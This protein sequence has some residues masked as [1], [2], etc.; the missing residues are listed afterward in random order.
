MPDHIATAEANANFAL[1]KY[2]GKRD[3]QRNLPSVG[4]ISL[5]VTG[6]FSR[7]TVHFRT[8]LDADVLQMDDLAVRGPRLERVARF[9]DIIRERSGLLRS[10]MIH[11]TNS[12]P[13]GAGLASS[14]SGFAALALASCHASGLSL[15]E[16]ELGALARRGSGSAARSMFGG[17]VEMHRGSMPDGSDA[18]AEQLAGPDHW[19]LV[20]LVVVTDTG[21]KSMGSTRA[22]SLS[23]ETSPFYDAWVS[24][25]ERDLALARQAIR[26]RDFQLLAD[27]SEHSCLKMHGVML[28]SR[29]SVMYWNAVTVAL[30]KAVRELRTAGVPV[31]FT[32]DA[33][34]QVKI[35]TEPGYRDRVYAAVRDVP[36]TRQILETK[37]GPGA[38]IVEAQ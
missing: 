8:D 32:I 29:P 35:V 28:A 6:L 19:P 2:W 15:S 3:D 18:V 9:L 10:A 24:G 20:V 14:A 21:P 26:D 1:I 17:F 27:I 31:F 36:G 23:R 16:N 38:R 33:G 25:Q 12:F 7:T 11:T 30:V 5:T 34:P 4:S 13:T 37:P 22:M